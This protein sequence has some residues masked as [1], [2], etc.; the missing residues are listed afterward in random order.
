MLCPKCGK[1]VN[2]NAGFCPNCGNAMNAQAF[3][4]PVMQQPVMQQY[5]PVKKP[6]EPLFPA[7]K[8]VFIGRLITII[9]L[10]VSAFFVLMT[11]IGLISSFAS[12]SRYSSGF[13]LFS[14]AF[15]MLG[16]AVVTGIAGIAA[17]VGLTAAAKYLENK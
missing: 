5:I 12:L 8:L 3:Q 4:Q 13:S 15:S 11:L 1:E 17:G 7:N 9:G 10:S 14:G 16:W 6:A 2:D